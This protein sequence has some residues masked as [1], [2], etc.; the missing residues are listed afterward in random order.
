MTRQKPALAD[1]EE[2]VADGTQEFALLSQNIPRQPYRQDLSKY[3]SPTLSSKASFMETQ[4]DA[5]AYNEQRPSSSFTLP[6]PSPSSDSP[7]DFELVLAT[8]EDIPALVQVHIDAYIY[9]QLT[10][11]LRRGT[12]PEKY[13]RWLTEM[14]QRSWSKTSKD[15]WILVAKRKSDGEPLG[16]AVYQLHDKAG[17]ETVQEETGE[18]G[19]RTIEG[20]IHMLRWGGCEAGI[21]RERMARDGDD[22]RSKDE[23]PAPP[24]GKSLEEVARAG[25]IAMHE[26][27]VPA[28]TR[29]MCKCFFHNTNHP[30]PDIGPYSSTSLSSI[31][32][33][34]H[35]YLLYYT[36]PTIFR[37][38][39]MPID[40]C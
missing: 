30:Y 37:P 3:N 14:V 5:R 32:F 8:Y 2:A 29:Y 15:T 23:T 34:L 17:E 18:E 21:G 33:L 28:K 6:P 7:S 35:F 39:F 16:C 31:P 27:W 10:Q 25:M 1:F 9:D 38:L 36:P 20:M 24:K 40:P 22:F 12:D 4:R 26:R 19:E 11:L 13:R